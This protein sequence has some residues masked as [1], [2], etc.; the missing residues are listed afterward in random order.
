MARRS[1]IVIAAAFLPVLIVPAIPAAAGGGCHAGA[2]QGK[3]DTVELIDACP[4]P[5]I[6]TIDR[7]GTVTFVNEDPFAHNVIGG[8]WGH[9]EDLN[10]GE[11]FTATF[12]EPGVYPWAC[13]YHPGMTGAIVVGDGTGVGNGAAV[14]VSSDSGAEP[15]PVVQVR[16]VTRQASSAPAVAGW[17]IGP[18]LG[19]GI[20]LGIA[21]LI[22]RRPRPAA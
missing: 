11:A 5:M 20:G 21:A 6:L 3:G 22:R 7:G 17:V 12:D 4:T 14:A 1:A 19:I 18:L 2:T 15:S 9:P 10:Q 13:W 16:A 8:A